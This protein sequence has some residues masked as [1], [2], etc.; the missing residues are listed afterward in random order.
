[1]CT[2]MTGAMACIAIGVI[3]ACS[4]TTQPSRAQSTEP[5]SL[6]FSLPFTTSTTTQTA[7]QPTGQTAP[8]GQQQAN[9]CLARPS[10]APPRGSHWFWRMDRQTRRRCWYLGS[11]SQKQRRAPAVRSEAAERGVP[12][13]AARP[14]EPQPDQVQPDEL[15]PDEQGEIAESAPDVAPTHPSSV[16]ATEFSAGWP[17]IPDG[18]SSSDTD[19]ATTAT[20]TAAPA[21]AETDTLATPEAEQEEMPLVWPVLTQAERAAAAQASEGAPSITQLLIFLTATAA[22]VALA[23]R[24]ILKLSSGFTGDRERQLPV[25]PVAPVIRPRTP[26]QP[27]SARERLRSDPSIEAMAEPTIARLREIAKRWD[28]PTR[29]PRQPRLAAYELEPEYK[30]DET[31]PRRRAAVA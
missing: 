26:E 13:P 25:E 7:A 21:P 20:A 1:M 22:F 6:P 5:F 8:Q 16:A 18:V 4:L 10:G 14:A 19:L 3:V 30:V 9:E 2:R 31:L 28:T 17:S 24:V 27:M 11:A 12:T 15:R 29:V 23:F